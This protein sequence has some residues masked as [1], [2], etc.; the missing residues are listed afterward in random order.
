MVKVVTVVRDKEMY[1]R[2]ISSNPYCD[3]T[4]LCLQDNT[5]ENLPI[6]VRY[7]RFLD[8]IEGE[9]PCWI[10]FCHEDWMPQ[11]S[12]SE[13]VGRLDQSYLYGPIG[14]FVEEYAAV[15]VIVPRGYVRQ[16]DK[17]GYRYVEITG[18]EIEGR[19][20]TFDCQCLIVHSSLVSRYSLR[21]DESL[22]FDM[23]VEDF[24]VSA[25]ERYGIESRTVF[26]PCVHHSSGKLSQ[27]F[28]NSLEYVRRK[29]AVSRKRYATIAGHL[30][31]FGG[32]SSRRVFKWKRIPWVIMRYKLLK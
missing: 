12:L 19:V 14:V 20:D 17:K 31:T 2:C 9:E 3:G 7:N 28:F 25:Y 4:E 24:C 13:T 26:L 21:F 8:S 23:Y 5:V 22:N 18:K 6:T 29:Y 1:R 11:A 32:D 16:T 15:D 10:C 27:R 30:N